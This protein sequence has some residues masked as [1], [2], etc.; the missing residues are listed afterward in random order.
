[1]IPLVQC[2]SV[3]RFLRSF[4]QLHGAAPGFRALSVLVLLGSIGCA[5][6][7]RR[8]P[9]QAP[10]DLAL[11]VVIQPARPEVA[12]E[13]AQLRP[14]VYLLQPGGEFAAVTGVIDPTVVKPAPLRYLD[15]REVDALWQLLRAGGFDPTVGEGPAGA[16][17]RPVRATSD[18]ACTVSIW[19]R[20]DGH[21]RWWHASIDG[22][23]AEPQA[24][25]LAR[26]CAF[27]AWEQDGIA[28]RTAPPRFDFGPDPYSSFKPPVSLVPVGFSK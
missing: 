13:Q 20:A 12:A 25:L 9:D 23:S 10:T 14:A 22:S 11:E 19:V 3:S 16:G 27:L 21:S 15:Q 4:G 6:A 28:P 2:R 5:S 17:S 24:A 1:M 26:L 8:T 7:A 18:A